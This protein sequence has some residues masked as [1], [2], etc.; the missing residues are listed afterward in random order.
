MAPNDPAISPE[1]R[2]SSAACPFLA[3]PCFV[4]S[5]QHPLRYFTCLHM[6]PSKAQLNQHSATHPL[7]LRVH[8]ITNDA[9]FV[10]QQSRLL[11]L[12]LVA[13]ERCGAW[14]VSPESRAAST[15]FKS[16]DG[17]RGQWAFSLRRL[18]LHLLTII[19]TEG[20][21]IIVDSC[22]RGKRT[23]IDL[24]LEACKTLT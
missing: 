18:N 13:N 19:G 6:A 11:D 16:T 8:S 1:R 9:D 22:K 21:C 15:Y 17:H 10:R 2:D 3:R 12:P 7:S 23:F 4:L 14:Y 5:N 20:G 24:L